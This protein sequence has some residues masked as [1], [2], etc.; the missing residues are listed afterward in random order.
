MAG[1]EGV[2]MQVSAW[3]RQP[4]Y[5]TRI[6]GSHGGKEFACKNIGLPL[7]WCSHLSVS[8]FL[9]LTAC[10]CS[11]MGG[12]AFFLQIQSHC[13]CYNRKKW[14]EHSTCLDGVKLVFNYTSYILKLVPN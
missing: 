10:F 2:C 14:L 7:Q 9:V 12:L 8:E 13:Y 5:F 11:L 3:I 6:Q 4:K 1:V